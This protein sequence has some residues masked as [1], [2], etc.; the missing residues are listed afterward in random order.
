MK[1]KKALLA[2][3][4][5]LSL[6][7]ILSCSS[8]SDF[9]SDLKVL[10]YEIISK[11]VSE[12][13]SK[14]FVELNVLIAGKDSITK[15]AVNNLLVHLYDSIMNTSG[16]K[17]HTSPNSCNIFIFLSNEHYES[18]MGQWI[19]NIS[20]A[21]ADTNPTI[22]LDE[23]QF[24]LIGET[25]IIINNLSLEKRK[26]I[27]IKVVAAE[28][29]SNQLAEKRYPIQI[30]DAQ[31]ENI[32]EINKHRERAQRNS[33]KHY[34][35]ADELHKKYRE[36]II[37]EYQISEEILSSISNEGLA[38]GWPFPKRKDSI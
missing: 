11:D 30:T 13:K 25:D 23:V 2:C 8:D 3:A 22:K 24:N 38:N 6:L 36:E 20:K 12:S 37:K 28:D 10:N 19:G 27:W 17:Y 15:E 18:D 16:Y 14:T 5:L 32:D 21:K 7:L 34:E 33:N 1:N 26:E 29:K 35:Y 31:L 4:S 9:N